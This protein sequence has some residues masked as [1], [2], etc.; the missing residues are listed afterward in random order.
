MAERADVAV[1]LI[2]RNRASQLR[3]ILP[4][5]AANTLLPSAVILAD[6]ASDDD[7]VDVFET[8]C[9]DLKLNGQ[10][11]RNP[12]GETDFRINTMRNL[13][14]QNSPTS[15][16]ILLDAD[17]VPSLT[18]IAAHMRM[19]DR[20]TK[21]FSTGP[22]LEAANADG[23]GPVNF[24]WGHEPCSS[25]SPRP[26]VP[27]PCWELV[28]GSNLGMHKA[29]AME[30]G[31]YDPQYDGAYGYDDLDFNFR[32]KHKGAACYGDFEAYV[33]HLPHDAYGKR[34]GNRNQQLYRRKTGGDLEY[35]FFVEQMNYG[36]NWAALYAD[37]LKDSMPGRPGHCGIPP[38]S[39]QPC[40][41]A[42]RWAATNVGGK[43]L[44]KLAMEKLFARFFKREKQ[45]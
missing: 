45:E 26:D 28:P 13:G 8:L 2:S 30:I 10:A 12:P 33:I 32:A 25:M 37:F 40:I 7:T 34:T 41:Q 6:D 11:L 29:F 22:R 19:L 1:V 43:F 35:P 18:H 16:V 15:R 5:I 17:H 24:M 38:L 42:T 23:T 39:G 4:A 14:I 44:L 31:L 20:S 36:K 3:R 21:A 9:R 27:V